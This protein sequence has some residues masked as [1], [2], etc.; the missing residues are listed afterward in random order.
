MAHA[1]ATGVPFAWPATRD[2]W[3]H[4]MRSDVIDLHPGRVGAPAKQPAGERERRAVGPADEAAPEEAEEE[5]HVLRADA[6]A[7]CGAA[8]GEFQ[9]RQESRHWSV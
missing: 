7:G 6:H 2:V 9:L 8:P 1:E 3:A 4:P 5:E